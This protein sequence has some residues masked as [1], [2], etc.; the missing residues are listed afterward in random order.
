[1]REETGRGIPLL[2][3]IAPDVTQEERRDIAQVAL[4]SGIDGLIVS[5][6]TVEWPPCL[7]G[8]HANEAGGLSGRPLFAPST[9]LLADMFSIA[10]SCSRREEPR[11]G[12]ARLRPGGDGADLDK[13]EAEP[14]HRVGDAGVLVE[15]G[16]E[17]DRVRKI[18]PRGV[19]SSSADPVR[20]QRHPKKI[21]PHP[22]REPAG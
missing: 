13:T 1:V 5:N 15:A 20:A 19:A 10:R 9:A 4:E 18:D 6:T 11:L 2:F 22:F 3:K 12:I 16:G 8:R 14:A 21:Y 17:P 7:A